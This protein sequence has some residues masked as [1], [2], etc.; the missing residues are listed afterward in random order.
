MGSAS[1]DRRHAHH[2]PLKTKDSS[3]PCVSTPAS[4]ANSALW[5]CLPCLRDAGAAI[6]TR[7]CGHAPPE[8]DAATG[9]ASRPLTSRG[10][11]LLRPVATQS[12]QNQT[13]GS[14]AR[15]RQALW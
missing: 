11:C 13:P 14:L 8:P 9:G 5:M 6:A 2:A 10:G 4:A 15:F 12:G 1:V 7:P 3:S